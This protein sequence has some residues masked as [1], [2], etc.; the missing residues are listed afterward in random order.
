MMLGML[1]NLSGFGRELLV[2]AYVGLWLFFLSHAVGAGDSG[3]VALGALA[4]A[5]LMRL[6][7]VFGEKVAIMQLREQHFVRVAEN[8][9]SKIPQLDLSK[10]QLRAGIA[11]FLQHDPRAD[12]MSLS[13]EM[14]V[15]LVAGTRIENLDSVRL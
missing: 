4:T 8:L 3:I 7:N 2:V 6:G 12:V 5:N 11:L 10:E 9:L 13:L 1:P 14:L 15:L